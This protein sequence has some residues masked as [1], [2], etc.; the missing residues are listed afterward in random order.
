M[1]EETLSLQK[2]PDKNAKIKFRVKAT[3]IAEDC[4]DGDSISQ[5]SGFMSIDSDPNSRFDL[6]DLNNEETEEDARKKA[7]AHM[8]KDQINRLKGLPPLSL[9][10]ESTGVIKESAVRLKTTVNRV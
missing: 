9:G 8:K 2:C 4:Q 10:K 6:D 7:L 1:V 3:L 5:M